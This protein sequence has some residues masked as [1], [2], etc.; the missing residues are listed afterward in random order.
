MKVVK[1]ACPRCE[2]DRELT[3]SGK[4]SECGFQVVP[5]DLVWLLLQQ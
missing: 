5:E 1:S 2:M 4:C 3:V